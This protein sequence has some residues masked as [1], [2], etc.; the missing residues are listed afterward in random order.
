MNFPVSRT[1]V[2]VTTGEDRAERPIE[3]YAECSAFVLLGE[4]GA[5]K[6]TEFRRVAKETKD[7]HYLTAR[8]FLALAV[9]PEWRN[10]TLFIDALDE[11]RAGSQDRRAPLDEIRSKLDQLG[12]PRFRISCRSVDW[13]GL[14]DQRHLSEVSQDLEVKILHLNPLADRD[15]MEIL[16]GLNVIAAPQEFVHAAEEYGLGALL[17]NPLT[18][19]LLAKSVAKQDWP[20][21][22]T[23]VYLR[24]SRLLVAEHNEEHQLGAGSH[25]SDDQKLHAA[26]RLFAIQILSGAEGYSISKNDGES[27]ISISS[28]QVD[29]PHLANAVLH[30]GLFKQGAPG[31][32]VG[33]H[34]AISEF[35]AGRFLANELAE[36][37]PVGRILS[38]MAGYDGVIL[39]Q[40][41]AV[42]AW[43]ATHSPVCRRELVSADPIGA[44]LYGDVATFPVDDRVHVLESIN[45]KS[46]DNPWFILN[47][48]SNDPRFGS[49]AS[50]DMTGYYAQTLDSPSR[51]DSH[52]VHAFFLLNVLKH[53]RPV[54][55]MSD[56]VPSVVE[57]DTWWL[58][59]RIEALRVLIGLPSSDTRRR[60]I[61]LNL[62]HR[63]SSGEV[64]DNDD[65]IRGF[66][67]RDLYPDVIGPEQ[68]LNHLRWPK[69]PDLLGTYTAFW[70]RSIAMHSTTSQL[71]V[72]MD[73]IADRLA[74]VS[75]VLGGRLIGFNPF[76]E[77]VPSIATRAILKSGGDVAP[78]RLF[79]WLEI[80]AHPELQISQRDRDQVCEWLASRKG[81]RRQ[82]FECCIDHCLEHANFGVC[83]SRIEPFLGLD[84]A[85]DYAQL[86]LTAAAHVE[87]PEALQVLEER[88]SSFLRAASAQ[89]AQ[90]VMDPPKSASVDE[91]QALGGHQEQIPFDVPRRHAAPAGRHQY[92][93]FKAHENA[94][95][96]NRCD[97]WTLFRLAR[98]YF[99]EHPE[100]SQGFPDTRLRATLLDDNK[101][102]EA[103][104]F[105]LRNA[106][107]HLDLPSV[108]E[109]ARMFGTCQIHY[110]ALPVLAGIEETELDGAVQFR[111]TG[112]LSKRLALTLHF[113]MPRMNPDPW[114]KSS[115]VA[116]C[117]PAP[118]WYC[119]LARDEPDF[120]AREFVRS[121]RSRLRGGATLLPYVASLDSESDHS[122]TA[123]MMVAGILR[124]FPSRSSNAQL[125]VLAH[126]LGLAR[127]HCDESEFAVVV[128]K[129][130][131]SR[132]M[133]IAQRVY[134]RAA[135]FLAMPDSHRSAFVEMLG[136]NQLRIRHLAEFLGHSVKQETSRD[137]FGHLHATDLEYLIR[138]VGS[139]YGPDRY[140]SASEN[141][142]SATSPPSVEGFMK[143]LIEQL[144]NCTSRAATE[145]L[146]RARSDESLRPWQFSLGG[147]ADNQ[148]AIRREAEFSY[149]SADAVCRVLSG[150]E[151]ANSAD[152]AALTADAIESLADNIRN[153]NTSD[154]KQYWI[155]TGSVSEWSPLNENDCRDALLS[156]LRAALSNLG[157]DCQPEPNYLD[158]KR[159][160]IRVAYSGC[161]VPLEIKKSNHPRV[162][163]SIQSQLIPKYMQD[164]ET[165]GCG[166]YVVFWFGR[167]FL[168]PPP[169]GRKPSG[170][171]QMREMLIESLTEDQR[172][173]VAIIVVDVSGDSTAAI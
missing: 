20:R 53:G 93:E 153:G 79:R 102:V 32:Y 47:V 90:G 72:L 106:I 70:N 131:Q 169:S 148:R 49:L 139:C 92:E 22:R 54:S 3:A 107:S 105:G 160:D 26:G 52:Q 59:V 16:R 6:S 88:A 111:S 125:E 78:R 147:A 155:R 96:E 152:L 168:Q 146:E 57:D 28:A 124:M 43:I 30:S 45:T 17:R 75:Q 23:E 40:F 35:L 1:V 46:K 112:G 29:D 95:R 100:S 31:Q 117:P 56:I 104:R 114:R 21:T 61:L 134:W 158:G 15:V 66:L 151:P 130:L 71:A 150:R 5:G 18:L 161:G 162:W 19:Q 91:L 99:G 82:V 163:S 36:G 80:L 33:F 118:A 101:L 123:P 167:G 14:N 83:L 116:G 127:Q 165:N 65:E 98:I 121:A 37:L 154:W 85:S 115:P 94:L 81:L 10:N 122:K 136:T 172:R 109:F 51:T 25:I 39:P 129:K 84:D 141:D 8:N 74:E 119:R 89:I 140:Q 110:L 58:K 137:L 24:A 159:A 144:G 157:I 149:G 38:L 156:D 9:R 44:M 62:C 126:L 135:A 64:A 145:A 97:P 60:E 50:S 166:I 86:C 164:P 103:V 108:D 120:V 138:V 143:S 113:G 55:E 73:Q 4:A 69:E 133:A 11:R 142:Q 68:I 12:R 170:S 63:V 77:F 171:A 27:C 128:E 42:A 2:E 13:L 48:Q 67:L 41:R 87:D 173:T 34:T 76:L 7:G 132:S